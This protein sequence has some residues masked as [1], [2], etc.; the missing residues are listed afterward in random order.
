MARRFAAEGILSPRRLR[1]RAR[2]DRFSGRSHVWVMSVIPRSGRK[3]TI[4]QKRRAGGPL[5][6]SARRHFSGTGTMSDQFVSV[7]TLE[8]RFEGDILM[9]AL[10]EEG[11]PAI[12]RPFQE[13]AYATIFVPQKGWGQI[14]VPEEM[15]PKARE[16]I[17]EMLRE[18]RTAP[19]FSD[20]SE[21]DPLLWERLRAA[22]PE[23]VCHN[24]LVQYEEEHRA[25]VVP[26]LNA[27]FLITP[28]EEK[29]E[30]LDSPLHPRV[31]FELCLALLHYLL[32]AE[33]VPL[34]QKW[35]SEKD[36]PSG[37]S[38]FRGLHRLPTDSLIERFGADA[39]LFKTTS[40]LIGG[41]PVEL[42]DAAYGFEVLPRVPLLV[43]L[44]EGDDEFEPALHILFD[45]TVNIQLKAL[46]TIFALTRV[47]C[48]ALLA[49]AAEPIEGKDR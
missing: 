41:V 2:G 9:G 6:A 22:D 47:F 21:L 13:T 14:L 33:D 12:L 26:F 45:E 46:D 35:I 11:I 27:E 34:T 49:S 28:E 44:W 1:F 29:V 25:Y 42:G 8:D 17:E 40:D 18:V 20:P 36:I 39:K 32:E 5:W 37:E 23:T 43:I 7:C 31:D 38:F 30:P 24:A 10:S 4:L 15:A 16:I 48:K 3:R 19:L